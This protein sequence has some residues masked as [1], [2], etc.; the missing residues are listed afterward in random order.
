MTM[1]NVIKF[2]TIINYIFLHSHISIKD[3][4]EIATLQGYNPKEASLLLQH[5]LRS[6]HFTQYK[7]EI[8]VKI[9]RT[10]TKIWL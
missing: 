10:S 9:G 8:F 4:Y 2:N 6:K 5:L 1:E 7:G 3:F